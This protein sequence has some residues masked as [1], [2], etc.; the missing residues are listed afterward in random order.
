M[1]LRQSSDE[2][3]KGFLRA[4]V[5][6]PLPNR[7]PYPVV[8]ILIVVLAAGFTA[9]ALNSYRFDPWLFMPLTVSLACLPVPEIIRVLKRERIRVWYNGLSCGGLFL[10]WWQIAGVRW[11]SEP[12][13]HGGFSILHVPL[14]FE[15]HVPITVFLRYKDRGIKLVTSVHWKDFEKLE[16]ALA[17]AHTFWAEGIY[18]RPSP[19]RH[20]YFQR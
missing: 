11:S 18:Q 13:I 4:S 5:K 10:Q 6:G 17:E 19:T 3:D 9:L 20:S 2:L 8:E 12:E 16:R 1:L 15:A 14:W 7:T